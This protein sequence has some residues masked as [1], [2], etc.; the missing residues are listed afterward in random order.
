MISN[1]IEEVAKFLFMLIFEIFLMW[2]GEI[3]LFILGS[4][5]NFKKSFLYFR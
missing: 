5:D 3:V 2:T 1:I 4:L